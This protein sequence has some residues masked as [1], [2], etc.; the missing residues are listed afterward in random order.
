MDQGE[1]V[2]SGFWSG[3]VKYGLAA[4]IVFFYITTI[5][6]FPYTP[7]DTYIYL[8][9]AKNI[10]N[11]DGFSFNTGMPSLGVPSPLWTFLISAGSF[12]RLDPY[13][14]AKTFD[15]VFASLSIIQVFILGFVILRNKV[16]AVIAAILFSFDAWFLRWSGT[17]METSLA[18]LL[19]I[20]VISYAYRNE[21]L[22]AAFV[23]AVLTLVRPEG[24]LLFLVV[25]AD[26]FLNSTDSKPVV[27]SF[28]ASVGIYV[29][30]L[31][32]WLIF[33][34]FHFGTVIPNTLAAK[35]GSG[36]SLPGVWETLL[37]SLQVVAATQLIPSLLL[38]VGVVEA[39]RSKQWAARRVEL[40]PL[41][42]IAALFGG[43]A[44]E[45]VQVVSRYL[46]PTIPL[47]IIYGMW[48]LK[49][50]VESWGLPIHGGF[51]VAVFIA[52]LTVFQSQV[53]YQKQMVPHMKNFTAGMNSCL[54]PIAYWLRS[55]AGPDATVL[56]SDAGM[57]GYVS[58]KNFYDAAGLIT[59]NLKRS[60]DGVTYDEGM[61]RKQ[62]ESVVR[63]DYIVD[64]SEFRERLKSESVRPVMSIEFPGWAISKTD[65][66]FYTLYKVSK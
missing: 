53:V 36:F 59:P 64:H 47:V 25:Q 21:Y 49:Q 19:T 56:T 48:G 7:D 39:W 51:Q 4:A 20:L 38:I 2:L 28:I 26:N 30:V 27:R 55:N 34:Y 1:R 13:I 29:G 65:T 15:L 43:Y 9:Y 66:V 23:C 58:D 33:S 10:A 22:V 62:Y 8:Q 57:L 37:D 60:F 5:L 44:L 12:L 18:I 63:P 31:T 52:L 46:L 45:N 32:P 11:G 3:M 42:W 41:V 40:F 61:L 54:K 14:V 16:F 24:I 6:H 50:I 17:G 35:T